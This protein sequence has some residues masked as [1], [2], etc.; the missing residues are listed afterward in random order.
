[1]AFMKGFSDGQLN[2]VA[3]FMEQYIQH[4]DQCIE[5]SESNGESRQ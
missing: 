5:E 4:I 1:M 2:Q 3:D